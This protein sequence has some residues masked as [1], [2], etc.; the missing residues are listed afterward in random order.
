MTGQCCCGGLPFFSSEK[1]VVR[2][3]QKRSVSAWPGNSRTRRTGV[4]PQQVCRAVSFSRI[5]AFIFRLITDVFRDL[6]YFFSVSGLPNTSYSEQTINQKG[7][8]N[9][10]KN[11][12]M[13]HNCAHAEER[14]FCSD[15]VSSTFAD[16]GLSATGGQ[17]SPCSSIIQIST[18]DKSDCASK[19][20]SF[21]S[22]SEYKNPHGTGTLTATT[23]R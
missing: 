2:R 6:V 3:K 23:S 9:L 18:V 5:V 19:H 11:R 17:L 14:S 7:K 16:R 13:W 10:A 20:D 8:E 15:R 12:S 4:W 21:G 1:R 22:G